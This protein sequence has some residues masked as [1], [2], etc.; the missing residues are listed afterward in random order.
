MGNLYDE[1]SMKTAFF[2]CFIVLLS[3]SVVVPIAID[4]GREHGMGEVSAIFTPGR[5]S[6]ENVLRVLTPALS[7]EASLSFSMLFFVLGRLGKPLV[8][9]SYGRILLAFFMSLSGFI[10]SLYYT[11]ISN[12]TGTATPLLALYVLIGILLAG[13]AFM[14]LTID[15]IISQLSKE[16]SVCD[17]FSK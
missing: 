8:G 3:L 12:M 5:F 14:M 10:A 15:G 17:V 16:K 13:L 11:C 2:Y 4:I 1:E 7:M 9:F 6:T